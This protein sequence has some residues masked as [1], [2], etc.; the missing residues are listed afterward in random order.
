MSP[1]I[2]W[3]QIS[4]LGRGKFLRRKAKDPQRGAKGYRKGSNWQWSRALRGGLGSGRVS[5]EELWGR[6][7]E[8]QK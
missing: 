5:W 1:Q 7:A 6:N 8:T 4:V 3:E 2:N